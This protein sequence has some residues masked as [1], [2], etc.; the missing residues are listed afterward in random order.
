M[1]YRIKRIETKEQIKTCERFEIGHY[2]WK[3]IMAPKAYGWMGYLEKKGFYVQ[4]VCEE[5][6]PKRTFENF[7]DNVYQ[8]SAME[9]FLAFP[10]KGEELTNNVMYTNFEVN[11]NAA[12]YIAYGK[13]RQG[14]QFMPEKYLE[15]VDCQ[16]VIDEGKWSVS[17]LIPERFLCEECGIGN[18]NADTEIYCNFYKISESEE[19]EH[20]G[21]F[22]RIESETPNF[23][24]PVCFAKA[25][26]E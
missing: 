14:R 24:L 4:M 17:F 2:M 11:S 6:D 16:G 12:M 22:S 8:D 25:I 7:K 20:Y 1:E 5:S 23:H 18:I 9:V 15:I 26:I 21:S 19:I 13:G 10:E 3:N